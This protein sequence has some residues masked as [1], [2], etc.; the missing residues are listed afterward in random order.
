MALPYS[1]KST[2]PAYLTQCACFICRKSYKKDLA[3]PRYTPPCPE[4]SKPLIPMG[5]YFRAPRKVDVAQWKKV[6]MLY[7]AGVYFGGRQS[8][9]LGKFPDTL[10]AAKAFIEKN[11]NT[12]QRGADARVRRRALAIAELDQRKA[13]RKKAVLRNS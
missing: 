11:S 10:R 2:G 9:E 13:K 7:C 4:C 3:N 5:R 8:W 1:R 6:E 12:L